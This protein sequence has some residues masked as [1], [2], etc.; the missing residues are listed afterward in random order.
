MW[1]E[2]AEAALPDIIASSG[3]KLV[4][5]A[6]VD[7]F[8]ITLSQQNPWFDS[9]PVDYPNV[10]FRAL[11][12]D[13]E[14]Q[15]NIEATPTFVFFL[16]GKEVARVVGAEKHRLTT[17]LK[18]WDRQTFCRDMLY[19]MGF[20]STQVAAALSAAAGD[21]ID[22]C[23]SYLEQLQDS[24]DR[25]IEETSQAL[26]SRGFDRDLVRNAVGR[27]G[28]DSVESYIALL[29]Q[30]TQV[31]APEERESDQLSRIRAKFGGVRRQPADDA[32]KREQ[33]QLRDQVT[34]ARARG[35]A[36]LADFVS[37]R[38]RPPS[39]VD[40]DCTLKLVFEDG[41]EIVQK[42]KANETVDAVC[43]FLTRNF[44]RAKKK[45][46]V[47]ETL[48]PK[49]TIDRPRFGETLAALRLVPRGQLVV[50][51]LSESEQ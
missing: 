16:R 23:V 50:R 43:Q 28:A 22:D 42:F 1:E 6:F 14:S 44:E 33:D 45:P 19:E 10:L 20:N 27:L 24:E 5:A 13:P 47:F 8:P 12:A 17:A 25:S 34:Q 3:K 18:K 37:T 30:I 2:I 32:H 4:L 38:P 41:M 35:D 46:F 36:A 31:D 11:A 9:L 40:G 7:D 51:F 48:F 15:Y 29:E 49:Q 26:I 39:R 21:S